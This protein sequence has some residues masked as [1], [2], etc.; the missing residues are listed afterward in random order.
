MFNCCTARVITQHN[1]TKQLN[2]T[3]FYVH[4]QKKIL[5]PAT[6]NERE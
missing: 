4:N 3:L 5:P 6:N 2:M 1:T